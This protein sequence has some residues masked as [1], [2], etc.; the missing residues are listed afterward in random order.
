[1]IGEMF[2]LA[3]LE[4]CE[5]VVLK[6]QF[7]V[8]CIDNNPLPTHLLSSTLHVHQTSSKR[9]RRVARSALLLVGGPRLGTTGVTSV[10]LRGTIVDCQCKFDPRLVMDVSKSPLRKNGSSKRKTRGST[11]PG[12][13]PSRWT[14]LPAPR[15]ITKS[16]PMTVD[17]VVELASRSGSK[18]GDSLLSI[19]DLLGLNLP[20]GTLLGTPSHSP[21]GPYGPSRTYQ[22]ED[23]F[24]R[25][26]STPVK[27]HQRSLDSAFHSTPQSPC[28]QSPFKGSP[29]YSDC[30]SPTM[31]HSLLQSFNSSR[32]NSPAD[33]DTSNSGLSSFDNSINDL[34]SCLSLG[35]S[36]LQPQSLIAHA[37]LQ[38]SFLGVSPMDQEL[39]NLQARQ[40]ISPLHPAT[41]RYLQQQQQQQ[42]QS[43]QASLLSSLLQY[44]P[45][46]VSQGTEFGGKS[47]SPPSPPALP[48]SASPPTNDNASLDR[49]ARFHRNSACE[50][51]GAREAQWW[52]SNIRL[53]RSI[54]ALHDATCTWSGNLPPR[55]P[56]N[57][58]Y[59]C[60][61]FLGGVP[62]D[63]SEMSL[64]GAFKQFGGIHVEWPGK[65]Q[66]A[67]QPKGYVYIIFESE[68]QV[69]T[70][71][72]TS[73][74]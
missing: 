52:L 12:A 40:S 6:T 56:K 32:T 54:E 69:S 62:W 68:K 5:Q 66:A 48:L 28:Y 23:H 65:E 47:C 31:E 16:S 7:H 46:R 18:P 70:Q 33:S 8:G 55:A 71:T 43:L 29:P 64:I 63:I 13:D 3:L 38:N 51:F 26:T 20:R 49:A 22:N 34:M 53:V 39:A 21:G 30:G 37:A 58:A 60:K 61:V 11:T 41:L 14:P 73:T 10:R 19:S 17:Q 74:Q 42:Q 36:P 59:S 27:A 72:N 2:S 9:R 1:M 15:A 4:Y 35:Q 57:S 45:S 25:D 44:P 67:S 50:L 24:Y